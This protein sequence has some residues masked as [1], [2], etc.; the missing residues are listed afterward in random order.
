MFQLSE[1]EDLMVWMQTAAFST[2]RK[3]YGKIEVDLEPNTTIMVDIQN[4]YNT[5]SFDGTKKLVL[6]TS[7]W[8]GGKNAFLGIAYLTIGGLCLLLAMSF[9]VLYV[10]YPR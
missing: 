9:L 7:S 6:S 10:Y 2:F 8:I 3:L 5:Y 1:Q 4:Q